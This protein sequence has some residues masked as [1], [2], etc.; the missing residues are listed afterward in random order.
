[1][2]EI[3]L[4]R[5]LGLIQT[6]D[7]GP[8]KLLQLLW[9]RIETD[10]RFKISERRCTKAP[11]IIRRKSGKERFQNGTISAE[12]MTKPTNLYW[13]HFGSNHRFGCDIQRNTAAFMRKVNFGEIAF[14]DN[15]CTLWNDDKAAGAS[16][17]YP[18][19]IQKCWL[20]VNDGN[21]VMGD[22][23]DSDNGRRRQDSLALT[24]IHKELIEYAESSSV[25][26]RAVRTFD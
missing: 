10:H 25:L 18:K 12:A 2:H 1:M 24:N 16:I 23:M 15:L 7:Y 3:E 14:T 11:F 17:S 5:R 22:F 6:S 8:H 26:T 9:T 20:L 13:Y 19:F 4:A 21:D